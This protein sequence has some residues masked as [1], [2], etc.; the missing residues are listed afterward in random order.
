MALHRSGARPRHRDPRPRSSLF[1][2]R[3][4]GLLAD[5]R[6]LFSALEPLPLLGMVVHA[7]YDA[8]AQHMK[9]TNRTALYWMMAEA[10]GSAPFRVNDGDS[11][12]RCTC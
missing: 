12:V 11:D 5:N 2:D 1:L 3:D 6:R 7:V 10:F 9:T 8:G 4:A